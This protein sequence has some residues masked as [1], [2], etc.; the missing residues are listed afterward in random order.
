MNLK[1]TVYQLGF[2]YYSFLFWNDSGEGYNFDQKVGN[3]DLVFYNF[4]YC[5]YI[6]YYCCQ[7][8]NFFFFDV[9]FYSQFFLGGNDYQMYFQIYRRYYYI[10]LY[11]IK[12]SYILGYRQRIQVDNF[13]VIMVIIRIV[14]NK[15]SI[16]KVGLS[17]FQL[18]VYVYDFFIIVLLFFVF[19]L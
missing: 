6:F 5:C 3:C 8:Y 18:L 1:S 15:E 19:G 14:S 10:Y 11:I 4:G 2:F 13:K 12:F 17:G 16:K 7:S 9:Y